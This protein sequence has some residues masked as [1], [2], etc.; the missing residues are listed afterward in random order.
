MDRREGSE[1]TK[2][3]HWLEALDGGQLRP[4]GDSTEDMQSAGSVPDERPVPEPPVPLGPFQLMAEIGRGGM[5]V[6]Y[7]AYEPALRRE[8]ALKLLRRVPSEANLQRFREEAQV[9]AQLQH[10]GIVP[11]Y[12]IG[13]TD[14]GH[15]YYT[16]RLVRGPTLEEVVSESRGD[17][18]GEEQGP[19]AREYSRFQLLQVF[20]TVCRT[21]AYAHAREVVHRDLKP[22]NVMLGPYGSVHVLDWGLAKLVKPSPR[23]ETPAAPLPLQHPPEAPVRLTGGGRLDTHLGQIVG[24]PTYMAPEQARGELAVGPAA[25]VYALGG[26]LYHL[27]TGRPPRDGNQLQVY[28]ALSEGLSPPRPRSIDPTIPADL[29]GLCLSTLVRD[30][31][32]RLGSA[33]ALADAVQ[34]YLEGRPLTTSPETDS[35][36][37]RTYNTRTYR[38]PSVTVDVVPL[39]TAA[40]GPPQVLLR[41]REA[42]PFEGTWALPGTFLKLEERLL[43]TARRTLRAKAGLP[44][45]D[46]TLEPL[47]VWDGLERDPRTRVIAHVFV[48][49]LGREAPRTKE[50]HLR[51]FRLEP[52][53]PVTLTP[54]DDDVERP[55]EVAFDHAQILAAALKAL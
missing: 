41:W 27:L 3:Q 48:A 13:E 8:V 43:E 2:T 22:S 18:D 30:P 34:A 4:A 9:T 24:T 46:V 40:T 28:A 47:G 25:D 12:A 37:L 23:S 5:G 45:I 55:F 20:L 10:P 44:S 32:Q 7:R 36:F 19:E 38:R 54:V 1:D 29:E 51:W 17:L 53:D 42:P 33:E 14:D 31:A 50:P 26:I 6:V 16:M 39:V 21:V 11:V 15:V 52:G 49:R 35:S